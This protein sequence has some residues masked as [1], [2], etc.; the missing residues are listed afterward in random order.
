MM[1][2]QI[3]AAGQVLTITF[4]GDAALKANCKVLDRKN[5]FAIVLIDGKIER[6]KIYTSYDGSEFI[7]PYGK[8]SMCP[9]ARIK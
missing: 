8:Y 4:I 5:S 1:A 2:T 9:T 3:I 7:Y 6:K